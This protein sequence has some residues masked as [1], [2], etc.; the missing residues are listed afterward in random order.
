M[1]KKK[2]H[3]FAEADSLGQGLSIELGGSDANQD[4][5]DWLDT[6][7]KP[8]NYALSGKYSGGIPVGRL[9][10]FFG[11]ESSGKTALATQA[12]ISTQ[13]KGGVAVFFDHEHAF[14]LARA[15][16][17]GL[18]DAEDCWIYKQPQTAEQSFKMVDTVVDY[19]QHQDSDRY[20]TIVIDSVA[21][22]VTKA[23]LEIDY[24][25]QNMKTMLSLP[26]LLSA[27]LKKLSRK[28]NQGNITLLLINQTRDNPGV[29]FGSKEK[30]TGGKALKFF[31]SVRLK[32]SKIGPIKE[33]DEIIGDY[34]R[35]ETIKNKTFEPFKTCTYISSYSKGIDMAGSHLHYALENGWITKKGG[36]L[37][38]DEQS[39]REKDLVKS[40]DESPEWYQRLMDMYDDS[41]EAD[42]NGEVVGE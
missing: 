27:S 25:E 16:H 19:I 1:A 3:K 36:W 11:G 26:A 32:L 42:E 40:L 5:R 39:W 22:M 38:W 10:E 9:V 35:A 30:T 24:D 21:A 4:V 31:C 8:L 17:L 29:M 23:E 14:S 20:V 13:Q 15:K 28:V 41:A 34:V 12:L 2:Q 37:E 6:G 33:G 18:S 7:I